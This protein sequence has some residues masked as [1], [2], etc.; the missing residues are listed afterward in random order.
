MA[1]RKSGIVWKRPPRI[2]IQGLDDY[3]RRVYV[4][5][6]A[7]GNLIGQKMQDEA[8]RDASWTDR[9]GNARSGLFH[10][11]IEDAA[12]HIVTVYLAHTVKYG[13]ALELSFGGRFA[14]ILP[15]LQNNFPEIKRM[16]DGIF[17]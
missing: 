2:L 5:I 9:T 12:R 1:R 6:V 7:V 8:R 10:Q 15:T 11:V 4:A 17:K 16:L 14:I 3:E 13:G